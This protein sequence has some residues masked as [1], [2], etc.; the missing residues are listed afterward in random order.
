MA[1]IK[2]SQLPT[3]S[4]I[5]SDDY[6]PIVE[7]S[8]AQTQRADFSLLLN[9]ITSS[10][11]NTLT[12][13]SLTASVSG[14]FV[15]DGS[16]IT[17][18]TGE[19]DGTHTGDA[20]ITGTLSI[21]NG[22]V[23]LTEN[24]YFFQGSST[25]G[26]NVSLIGV[27]SSDQIFIG[28]AGY[29]NIIDD[30]TYVSG[31]LEVSGAVGIGT[32]SPSAKLDVTEDI[33]V[34]S[35]TV[36]KGASSV[37]TNTAFGYTALDSITTA[38]YNTAIGYEALNSLVSTPNDYNTAVGYRAGRVSTGYGN[39]FIGANVGTSITTGVYNTILGSNYAGAAAQSQTVVITDGVGNERF[40]ADS[41]GNVGI[42]TTVPSTTLVVQTNGSELIDLS[43][44]PNATLQFGSLSSTP[45]PGLAARQTNTGVSGLWHIAATP[46]SSTA[47]LGDM[48][49]EVRE[50]NNSDFGT[51]VGKT[52]FSFTRF[53][54]QLMTIMRDGKVGIGTASPSEKLEVVGDSIFSGSVEVSG[55]LRADVEVSGNITAASYTLSAAD[56][57]KTLLFSSSATQDITCSSGLDVGYNVTVVQAGTGQLNFS[58]SGVT[59]VNR[60][61]HTS[62]AG[63]Y[64]AV[65]VIVL[66]GTQYLVVGDTA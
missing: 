20:E 41:A 58:G 25:G 6:M 50:N 53:S 37:A 3:A 24:A 2:I 35:L 47:P 29:Q 26:S 54:N 9:Y 45:T 52:A 63:Q 51:T 22:H 66:N 10:T 36:G 4:A 17:G 64:S 56:Y 28:N 13:T 18:V 21:K 19:W 60:F 27:N 39:T 57:G 16:G 7:N 44:A 38:Q 34:N 31:N 32:T 1:N 30:D 33:L 23:N 43:A 40:Y 46:D 5:T 15:G 12:V 59:L 62:S 49:F 55:T 42:G 48:V 61:A 8:L 11:F 65:S 14:T